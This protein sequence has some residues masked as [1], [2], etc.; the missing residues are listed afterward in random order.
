M[1]NASAPV[2]QL[3]LGQATITIFNVGDIEEAFALT[4]PEDDHDPALEAGFAEPQV[5]PFQAVHV[6][7]P[8][9]SLMVDAF[10]FG[11]IT[12]LMGFAPPAGHIPPPDLLTQMRATR[13]DPDAVT[14]LVLTH[15]HFDHYS[16]VTVERDSRRE[17]TFPKARC[18]AGRSDWD[19]PEGEKLRAEEAHE[20]MDVLFRAGRVTLM[21]GERELVP[22]VRLISTPGE[23][24]GHLIVRVASEGQ[25]LYAVGDLLHYPVEAEHPRWMVD[26]AD[27][28]KTLASRRALIRAALPERA[29]L[30]AA[31]I[32][33]VGRLEGT[34]ERAV[35]TLV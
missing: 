3:R 34:P 5:L 20:T 9:A 28:E 29:L 2:R 10:D 31:H 16:G 22:G 7:L 8:G 6:A 26:W 30:V 19:T 23:S 12:S 25:M 18:F 4:V 15:A 11:A 13:I 35:W 32:P 17:P 21:E 1:A 33:G 27:S 14:H 24:P